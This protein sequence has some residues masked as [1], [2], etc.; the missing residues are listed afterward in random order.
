MKDFQTLAQ[1]PDFPLILLQLSI[2]RSLMDSSW[3]V[4]E[5]R[6]QENLYTKSLKALNGMVEK[7]NILECIYL[8]KSKR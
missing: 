4:E 6:L 8:L 5:R 1:S 7:R 3:E 2:S